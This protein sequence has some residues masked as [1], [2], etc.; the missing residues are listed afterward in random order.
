MV[1]Y[2]SVKGTGPA[3]DFTYLSA[4]PLSHM[5][6]FSLAHPLPRFPLV[7]YTWTESQDALILSLH[8]HHGPDWALIA[9]E[10]N[11]AFGVTNLMVKNHWPSV[12][13]KPGL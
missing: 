11:Q 5:P 1:E 2:V 7:Q 4:A 6:L 8:R 12:K 3:M 9:R 10:L 13:K